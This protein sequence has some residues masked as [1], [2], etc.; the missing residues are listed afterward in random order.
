MR[1]L[2]RERLPSLQT[3]PPIS[4]DPF[5]QKSPVMGGA[6]LLPSLP[7]LS[8]SSL[9]IPPQIVRSPLIP[10]IIAI[11]FC[12]ALIFFMARSSRFGG[13]L[14]A[15][16]STAEILS[17]WHSSAHPSRAGAA[18]CVNPCTHPFYALSGLLL[19]VFYSHV[20][21][22]TVSGVLLLCAVLFYFCF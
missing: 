20:F 3:L 4:S 19:V 11:I 6:L 15:T 7:S 16:L 21:W 22:L 1:F 14:A 8:F 18:V 5:I 17:S 2:E 13:F 12:F 9:S 10:S